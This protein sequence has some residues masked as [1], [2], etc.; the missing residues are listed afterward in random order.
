MWRPASRGW[1]VFLVTGLWVTGRKAPG[2]VPLSPRHAEGL[3]ADAIRHVGR[4]CQVSAHLHVTLLPHV[5]TFPAEGAGMAEH[6]TLWASSSRPN[7]RQ[8]TG[9]LWPV[10][11]S[12]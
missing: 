7:P 1:D 12:G 2:R 8:P 3:P 9:R 4:V 6:P 10:W 5:P 11:L